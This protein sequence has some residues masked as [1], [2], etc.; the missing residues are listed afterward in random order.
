MYRVR[1]LPAASRELGHLDKPVGRRVVERL[2][3]LAEHIENVK[4]EPLAGSLAGLYKLRVGDYRIIYEV[5]YEEQTIIVHL[6]GHRSAVYR[7]R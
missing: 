7:K 1:L 4:P 6:I 2:H 5:L 3:W